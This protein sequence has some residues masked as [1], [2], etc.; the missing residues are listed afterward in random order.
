MG[1]DGVL[2]SNESP[3]LFSTRERCRW[4][5]GLFSLSLIRLELKDVRGFK[6][7]LESTLD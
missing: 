4:C 2:M 6:L 5:F 1:W 7:L 3:P